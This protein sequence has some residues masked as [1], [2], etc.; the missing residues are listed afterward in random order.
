MLSFINFEDG[1]K[2]SVTGNDWTLGSSTTIEEGGK[3]GNCILTKPNGSTSSTKNNG[4]NYGENAENV[5]LYNG[6]IA[7]WYNANGGISGGTGSHILK[8][9]LGFNRIG[10]YIY[11]FGNGSSG[12]SFRATI[13]RAYSSS[14]YKSELD[15]V[16]LGIT[17]S[18]FVHLALTWTE[19]RVVKMYVNGEYKQTWNVTEEIWNKMVAKDT[20]AFGIDHGSETAGGGEGF[21]DEVG[22]WDRA[23]ADSEIKSLYNAG[24]NGITY[25]FN[26]V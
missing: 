18:E 12:Y 1:A 11:I 26:G 25:P 4:N 2:D 9:D 3:V 23:L 20:D 5:G 24:I 8:L 7:C 16:S 10:L 13:N 19:D 6:S 17:S 14:G 22:F 21:V 15:L